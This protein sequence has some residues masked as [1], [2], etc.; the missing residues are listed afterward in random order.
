MEHWRLVPPA[1]LLSCRYGPRKNT[2]RELLSGRRGPCTNTGGRIDLARAESGM[3]LCSG[4]RFVRRSRHADS[5]RREFQCLVWVRGA[6]SARTPTNTIRQP[7]SELLEYGSLAASSD[8]PFGWSISTS[9]SPEILLIFWVNPAR[10]AAFT[11]LT[12]SAPDQV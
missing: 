7:R 2:L 12:P 10:L 5:T 4:E 6:A 1:A 3:P 9:I 8:A 11:C